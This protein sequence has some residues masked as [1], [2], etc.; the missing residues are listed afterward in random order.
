MPISTP[1]RIFLIIAVVAVFLV[2]LPL[3]LLSDQTD[4]YFAWTIKPAI[5]AAFLGSGYG[6]AAVA[7]WLALK[8]REWARIRA[9]VWVITTGL[10]LILI[11]T[12]LHLD[13]FH[14]Y[15]ETFSLRVW[16]WTWLFLYVVL[17][18]ALMAALWRQW[19]EPGRDSPVT[20][21]LP[22]G[23]RLAMRVLGVVMLMT[24][25]ALFVAPV[26]AETLWA[27]P[28]TPLTSRMTGSWFTAIGLSL[29]VAAR[30]ND[31]GRIRVV[32]AAYAVYP[33]LQCI[34]LARWPESVDWTTWPVWLLAGVLA[35]LFA[36][37]ITCLAGAR[38]R[39][40]G[41]SAANR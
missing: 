27:W 33:V 28:L 9:G 30:E 32:A 15:H 5:T 20:Q 11:A 16:A 29:L 35:A 17:G 18:P 31:Y 40:P 37:G 2:A 36:I 19:R 3:L 14:L 21:P 8:E 1:V 26:S 7:L 41:S 23:L 39:G 13:R 34:T 12:L 4:R 25:A 38:G 22:G 10:T 24:G 6:A